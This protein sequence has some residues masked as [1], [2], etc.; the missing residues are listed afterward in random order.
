M[1]WQFF[2]LAVRAQLPQA[3]RWYHLSICFW[4]STAP[5]PSLEASVSNRNSLVYSAKAGTGALIHTCFRASKALKASS[6]SNTFSDFLL[7]PSPEESIQ[8]LCNMCKSLYKLIIMAHEAEKGLNFYVGLGWFTFS[9]GSQIRIARPHTFLGDTVCQ[10][11][12]LFLTK[13]AL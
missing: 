2:P 7:A 6:S 11:I 9:N 1:E 5:S 8:W 3:T 4:E 10:V 13:T 12:N